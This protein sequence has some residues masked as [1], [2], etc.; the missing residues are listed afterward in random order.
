LSKWFG[1]TGR[2]FSD[3]F[4][5]LVHEKLPDGQI[6]NI[7]SHSPSVVVDC[8][9]SEWSPW[10]L[11]DNGCGSGTQRRSRVIEISEKNG[12][13]HCPRLNQVRTCR[14]FQTCQA[15]IR[16]QPHAKSE[17][18]DLETGDNAANSSYFDFK[19]GIPEMKRIKS[20]SWMPEGIISI[21]FFIIPQSLDERRLSRLHD[22][23]AQNLV[24]K[25]VRGTE[26]YK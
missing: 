5:V 17:S 6:F 25:I 13:K 12:G 2:D 22:L 23:E 9:V 18:I 20:R 11:C 14:S 8:A 16:S 15:G 26:G 1:R 10:S 7:G 3:S 21:R 19:R 24:E 4:I